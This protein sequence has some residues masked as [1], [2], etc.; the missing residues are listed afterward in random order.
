MMTEFQRTTSQIEREMEE[1]LA[2]ERFRAWLEGKDANVAVGYRMDHATQALVHFCHE[3]H[4]YGRGLV[5]ALHMGWF[6]QHMHGPRGRI[7]TGHVPPPT[8]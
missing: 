2:S 1:V 6:G 5:G 4:G 8:R 3:S 7:R